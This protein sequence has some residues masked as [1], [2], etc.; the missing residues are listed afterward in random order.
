MNSVQRQK[1]LPDQGYTRHCSDRRLAQALTPIADMPLS[2]PDDALTDARRACGAQARSA[3][4][5]RFLC[6][7]FAPEPARGDLW[8]LLAFNAE[9]ARTREVVS[10]PAL[11]EIRL[12]WWREAIDAAYANT[13]PTHPVVRALAAA[14]G[15]ARP[16]RAR[17]E[18]L[19]LAR[20]HDLTDDPMP[21][22][23]A[24]EDYADATSGE[25][26]VLA[27]DLLGVAA[28]AAQRAARHVGIAWALTGILRATPFLAAQRR[29]LL[30]ADLLAAERTSA[31]PLFIGRPEPGL[32]LV[33]RIVANSARR[34][35]TKAREVHADVPHAALP[36]LLPARLADRHLTRLEAIEFDVFAG[37]PSPSPALT[38]MRLWWAHACRRY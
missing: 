21:D 26:S 24:L 5:E 33:L 9:I 10:E 18:R 38:P 6:S 31:E 7:L 2:P 13:A 37:V 23:A 27:L 17:F 28:P 16:P 19:L 35:L 15:R 20:Q 22:L 25:L 3:D 32:R 30:P 11:G 36:T 29:L 8:A 34:H 14:I 1:H 4:R 12:Q